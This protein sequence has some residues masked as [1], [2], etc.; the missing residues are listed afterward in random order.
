[1]KQGLLN[2][3]AVVPPM[4]HMSLSSQAAAPSAPTWD[5]VQGAMSEERSTNNNATINNNTI[6]PL[7]ER[8]QQMAMA[9]PSMPHQPHFDPDNHNSHRQHSGMHQPMQ[10]PMGSMVRQPVL[11]GPTLLSGLSHIRIREKIRLSQILFGWERPNVYQIED[12]HGQEGHPLIFANEES[13][14]CERQCCPAGVRGWEM[15]ISLNGGHQGAIPYLRFRKPTAC[16]C[17]C[18]CR[19]VLE[20]HDMQHNFIAGTIEN[21]CECCGMRYIIKDNT[22]T[23]VL[24]VHGSCCQPGFCCRCPCDP[25]RHIEFDVKDIHSG[26]VVGCIRKTWG[27]FVR[28]IVSDSGLFE[29]EFGK[30]AHPQFKGLLIACALF[31]SEEYFT[32]GGGEQ[33]TD[34]F[35]MALLR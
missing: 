30:V 18:S 10:R 25:C 13:S 23:P 2:N 8:V 16:A 33:R 12:F 34:S 1:M 20:V 4:Q 19:P 6:P 28:D 15:D 14:C 27:G 22:G 21:P 31:I 26:E 32:R 35:A 5:Q 9:Q 7:A 29:V 11:D 17:C 3:E 24:E